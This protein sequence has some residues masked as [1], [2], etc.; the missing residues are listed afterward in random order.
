MAVIQKTL[1]AENLDRYQTFVTDTNPN[2]EYF[3]ITELADTLTGG[4]NAFLIQGSEYLVADTLIK[5]EIK[6]SQG[7]IIYHE[8][9]Q[10]IVSASVGSQEIVTEYYEGVSKV[11]AVH[12]YPDT[13]YGPATI[14]ILGELSSYNNNGLN[15]PIPIDWEGQYN[16][17]WQKQINVNPSLA[18]TTKIRFYKRPA[19][20]I[21]ET[22]SPIYTIVDG[23]KVESNVVSSFANIKISQM[24][25]FAG[26]VKRIKVF[27][28]S[29]GDI[30][31]SDLIQD[32]LVESKELLSTYELSG[33]VVG[34]GGLFTSETLQKLWIADGVTTQ[35]TSSRIDNGVKLNGS[36]YFKYSSSLNL[37][38]VSVYELGVDA[39]YSSST[40]SNMGIYIS[41]SNNGEYLIG[42]LNG[43]TPTKNLKD[44]TIQFT[45]PKAE[46]TA[47]LYF[48]Q[49]QNEWHLGNVSLKLTQDTAF[50]PSEIEFVTSMPTVIGNETYEF[51]FEFYDVNNNYVPVAVTQSALFTG[52]NNNLGGTITLISS[53]ASSSLSQLYAVSSSISGTMTVYSSS[54]SGSITTLSGSVSGS[55]TSLSSSVSSSITSLSSSV[56]ASNVLILSS[57]LSKVQQLANGQFSGSFIGDTVIYSPTIGGQQGYISSLF[58]VGTAP[59]IYLDARQSPRKI[60]I[61]GAIPS[62]Q[63]EYSGAYNN[64]NTSVYLDSDGKFSLGDKLSYTAGGLSVNGTINVTGGNAATQTYANTIGT[65]AVTSGSTAASIAGTNAALSASVAYNNAKSI[66]DSIANGSY[67]GGTLI[68]NGSIISPIIAGADGYISNVLKVG[69]NGIT[70]DGTN[71]AIYVGTGTYNNNNTPFYFKSGSTDIF[72]LGSKLTFDGTN[73]AI[74][75]G[76]TA[77]SLTLQA[78]VTVPNASVAGLGSLATRSSVNATYIDDN[79]I[80]TGKVVANTLDASHISALN[81]TGKT[82]TFTNGTIGGWTINPDKLSSPPDGSGYSRLT[83]SPS[84]LIAVNDTSGNPKLTI[85]AGD[86][87]NLGAGSSASIPF[88][89]YNFMSWS[90]AVSSIGSQS[91]YGTAF[92]FSVSAGG[93]YSGTISMSAVGGVATTPGGWSGYLWVGVAWEIASDSSFNNIIGTGTISSGGIS[94][95]G[96]VSIAA[97]TNSIAFSAP[98]SGTYWARLVWKRTQY[99]NTTATTQFYTKSSSAANVSLGSTVEA[100]EVTDKGFQVV[101]ATDTYFRIDR[102]SF[103]GAFVK[104][105]GALSATGNITAYASDKR[106]KENIK[107]IENPLDKVDKLNGVHYKWKDEVLDMGFKPDTMHDTGL[108]AQE[109]QE[110]LPDAVKF[111]PFDLHVNTNES[112]S[113]ENYLTV[114]YEKVVPL[115]VEAIKELRRELNELKK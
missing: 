105:G 73:L 71:K 111:A 21:S 51:H 15:T 47:S 28:T 69:T 115:L 32:V 94:S 12:V 70:L 42:T 55:I 19:A 1:F 103:S 68:S 57:S 60:F 80:T 101:N 64:A 52:G 62:G 88:A 43:I 38:D 5:I 95:A 100:T 76:I 30:S 2:S 26:D 44:Q 78:G 46:P 22:L 45:L 23:L 59:S 56:S 72:S 106:L 92:S 39:F 67:S 98:T 7:N 14:T 10:G 104:I 107:S 31:D 102:S 63:T 6:D 34:N 29:L 75:G 33:S 36:G 18:N 99:S 8:P 83:F 110:V 96:T 109:V 25:T 24:D 97:A 58:K 40:A 113:G 114:Q 108:L 84:P 66:A 50:S 48:S 90:D 16:V 112:K 87:T 35:L 20:S 93:T 61:G 85:R 4:K 49:S 89:S 37:S 27:R 9:G 53:S 65:N 3:K 79:S 82:A 41:G 54:A 86:L 17:K 11:V 74:Q 81:F 91:L 77:T 13:S